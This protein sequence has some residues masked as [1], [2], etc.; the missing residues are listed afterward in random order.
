[1]CRRRRCRR[2]QRGNP[3]ECV[4]RKRDAISCAVLSNMILCRRAVAVVVAPIRVREMLAN[5]TCVCVCSCV[6]GVCMS[7]VI[8]RIARKQAVLSGR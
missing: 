8:P 2:R 6:L 3:I 1:M 7:V 5:R 4:R